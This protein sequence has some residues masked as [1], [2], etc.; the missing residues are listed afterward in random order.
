[1]GHPLNAD[2]WGPPQLTHFIL[3][4]IELASLGLPD[5]AVFNGHLSNVCLPE[6]FGQ[7]VD[8]PQTVDT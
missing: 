2:E 4:L 7:A 6:H 5:K 8:A 3:T 1:M